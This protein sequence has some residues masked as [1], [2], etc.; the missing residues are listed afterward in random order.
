MIN[1]DDKQSKETQWVSSF[2]D[3]NAAVYFDSFEIEY[4]PQKV[5]SKIKEKTITHNIFRIQDDDSVMCGFYYITFIEYM[6][7]GK[8]LLDYTKLFSSNGYEKNA[9]ITYKCVKDKYDKRKCKPWL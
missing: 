5:L 8:A 1:L 3:K 2:I 7:A 6:L 9:K 4:I